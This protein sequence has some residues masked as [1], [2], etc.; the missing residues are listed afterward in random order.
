MPPDKQDPALLWDMLEAARE[1]REFVA[2]LTF[3]EYTRNRMAQRAVERS[4]EIIGEAAGNVS[5]VFQDEHPEI[6]WR[7][8]IGQRNV[9]AH[10]Y[11]EVRQERLWL[12]VTVKIPE[13]ILQL[14]P[15]VPAPDD[16]G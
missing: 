4:I 5:K 10:E 9:L 13:L 12:V 2:G 3:E 15:L 11:G 1:I 7:S 16:K 8:I 6:P 14:E